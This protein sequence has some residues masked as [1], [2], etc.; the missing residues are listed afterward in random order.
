MKWKM[1]FKLQG[2]VKDEFES[3]LNKERSLT[4]SLYSEISE[5]N[6]SLNNADRHQKEIAELRAKMQE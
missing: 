6:L 2:D 4:Q 3:L 1:K 5:L